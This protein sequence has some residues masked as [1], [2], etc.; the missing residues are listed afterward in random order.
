MNGRRHYAGGDLAR[1]LTIED[2]RH[3]ARRRLPR[4]LFEYVDGGAEDEVTLHRNRHAFANLALVPST[5]VDVSNRSLA[6]DLFGRSVAAPLVVAPTGFNGLLSERAD[7]ALARA[8]ARAGVPFTLSMAS[9]VPLEEVASEAGGRLW[10]QLYWVRDRDFIRRL[11]ARAQAASFEALVLTTD[12]QVSGGREWDRRNY[13]A[14]MALTLRNRLDVLAHPRWLWRI[15]RHGG[16]P[17]FANLRE[18]APPDAATVVDDMVALGR[19]MD[20][21]VN[22]EHLKWL[23]SLWPGRLL[24]KGVLSAADARS[25]IGH[26]ADGVI[27]SNHGGRQLDGA[28]SPLEVLPAIRD[29]LGPEAVILLD[30]GVRRGVDVVKARALGA[31]AVM[32]GRNGLYG[33]AAG[34]ESGAARA[35]EIL[36]QEIDRALALLGTPDIE[37]VDARVLHRRAN[38]Q[39][40]ATTSPLLEGVI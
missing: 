21:S 34:G 1:A 26:G 40:P 13:R 33:V 4:F 38:S 16:L 18:L 29:A 28:V 9:N 15:A 2:L 32:T 35:L 8:A 19:N 12:V 10:M 37:T 11:V 22:W 20:P 25:A 17:R 39:S 30:G 23:R 36:R 27:L 31:T 3:M 14:G 24:V 7:V 5:L 6:V